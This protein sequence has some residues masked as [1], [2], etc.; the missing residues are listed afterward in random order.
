M[1]DQNSD[2]P[3]EI[4]TMASDAAAPP[5]RRIRA[6]YLLVLVVPVLLF[7]GAVIGMY[8][9]PPALKRFFALTGLKPGAGSGSPIALPP[10]IVLPKDMAETIRA[11]DVV[12]LARLM[13]RGDISFVAPPYGAGDARVA[14]VLVAEGDVVEQGATVARM[15]NQAHLEG[16]ILLAEA[17]VAVRRA[18]LVQTR[19][20]VENSRREA[21]A[22]LARA[23]S[24]AAEAAAILSRTSKLSERLTSQAALDAAIAADRQSAA[25]VEK[26]EATLAR[27]AAADLDSQ[28][29]VVVA[30]RNV[31]AAVAELARARNDLI[32][33]RVLAPIS[34]TVLN[35][36]ARP[37]QRP[38]AEGLMELGDVSQMMAETE[39]YQDRI[40]LVTVGQPVELA[41][42]ALQRTLQG[43]V[44]SIGLTVG[45]QDLL[46]DDTAANTDARVVRVMVELDKA[47]SAIAARFTNLEV[48]ARIDTRARP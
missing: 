26:A 31:E 32:S 25:A 38:P 45:R 41:A 20:T 34:G 37:G 30:T 29:D 36:H 27:Y 4:M 21:L 11:S 28:P 15:D 12:G 46:S 17:N 23:R 14:E 47:S 7:S 24:A 9:Q 2:L 5:R 3:L 1:T 33:A 39:I 19:A 18:T 43:R 48:I 6:R 40:S 16:A 22:E 13:P 44:A 42:T 10:E 8:F 35:I